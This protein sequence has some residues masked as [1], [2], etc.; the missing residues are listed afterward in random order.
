MIT[1]LSGEDVV[2]HEQAA[3]GR[4]DSRGLQCRHCYSY[5]SRYR[6]IPHSKAAPISTCTAPATSSSPP[7]VLHRRKYLP[8][9]IHPHRDTRRNPGL[10][11]R[12]LPPAQ[13][14]IAIPF[15]SCS[16][17]S[18][19]SPSSESQA[20]STSLS[21][22]PSSGPP[23]SLPVSAQVGTRALAGVPC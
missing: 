1:S 6:S 21:G 7:N 15:S 16:H 8:A 22:P 3:R 18:N 5:S 2:L 23:H 20:G 19:K 14:L 17:L 10:P 13:S 4:I 12:W 11:N 9:Y